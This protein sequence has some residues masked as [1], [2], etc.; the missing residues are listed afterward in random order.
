VKNVLLLVH[1]DD[2]QE[3]RLQT[4]LDLTRALNGHLTGLDVTPPVMIAG[5][6][7][8]GFGEAAVISDERTSEAR[9]KAAL[10]ARLAQE[11]VSWD[12]LDAHGEI[13]SCVLKHCSLADLVVLNRKLDGFTVPDMHGIASKILM[14]ARVPI[15]A[16]P[17]DLGSKPNQQ[18]DFAPTC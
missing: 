18:L 17:E 5:E 8:A 7:Y 10:T 12:W 6:L 3:S 2:G 14:H 9:N 15:V 1:D 16:V 4:A 11:D 13:A